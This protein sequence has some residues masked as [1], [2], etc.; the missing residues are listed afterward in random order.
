M[1]NDK[2]FYISIYIFAVFLSSVSQIMLKRSASIKRSTKLMEYLN[3]MV[4]SAYMLFF[5]SIFITIFAYKV[6]PLSLGPVLESTSY[7]FIMILSVTFLKEKIS[8]KKLLGIALIIVG[9]I[10]STY[11][12]VY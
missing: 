5:I 6:L 7:L 3:I 2:W 12:N 1:M 9:G 11:F 10:V 8:K 4:I